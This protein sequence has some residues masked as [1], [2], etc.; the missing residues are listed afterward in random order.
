M[1]LIGSLP[2]AC[3][4]DNGEKVLLRCW[5]SLSR[6]IRRHPGKEAIANTTHRLQKDRLGRI[7]FN[8]TAQPHH[9]VVDGARIRIL[10]DSPNL[11]Q[12]FLAGNDAALIEDKI[13]QQVGLHQGKADGLIGSGELQRSKVDGASCE[14]EG[15][16][17]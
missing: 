3:R 10:V 12:Q 4:G 1:L 14:G 7:V 5:C 2:F 17:G 8:L 11:L 6:R 9:K 16:G 15:G 13:P